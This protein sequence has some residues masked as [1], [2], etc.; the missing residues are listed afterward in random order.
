ML[1]RITSERTC[2]TVFNLYEGRESVM[3]RRQPVSVSSD[4]ESSI[5]PN[6]NAGALSYDALNYYELID[7]AKWTSRSSVYTNN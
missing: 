2:L 7:R 6:E 3:N 1:Q 4:T 5:P